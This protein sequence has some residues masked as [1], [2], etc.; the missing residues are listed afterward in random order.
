MSTDLNPITVATSHPAIIVET[1][2]RRRID[3]IDEPA[4]PLGAKR[5]ALQIRRKRPAART[6]RLKVPSMESGALT[7][8]S[9]DETVAFTLRATA[10]GLVIERTQRQVLGIR[11]VQVL[12]FTDQPTFDRWCEFEPMRFEDALLYSHLRREGHAALTT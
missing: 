9:Q 3:R 8:S 10:L 4:R 5:A 12:V 2:S 1:L 7:L 11:L 6:G